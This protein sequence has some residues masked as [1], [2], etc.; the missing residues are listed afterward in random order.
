[1]R[2]RDK[3]AEMSIFNIQQSIVKYNKKSVIFCRLCRVAVGRE[4]NLLGICKI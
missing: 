3:I 1:M 4:E 2:V